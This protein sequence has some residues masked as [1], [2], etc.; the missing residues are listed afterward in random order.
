VR[1]DHGVHDLPLADRL[2]NDEI[3][4][5]LSIAFATAR[6]GCGTYNDYERGG[7]YMIDEIENL[8]LADY[9]YTLTPSI[10][11]ALRRADLLAPKGDQT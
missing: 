11:S 2:V 5:W 4:E 6:A 10:L 8:H 7:Q 9:T 1:R 3:H